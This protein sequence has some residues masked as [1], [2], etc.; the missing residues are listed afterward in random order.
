[1]LF[2]MLD[3]EPVKLE[4]GKVLEDAFFPHKPVR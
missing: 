4:D 3:A 1:M 2:V